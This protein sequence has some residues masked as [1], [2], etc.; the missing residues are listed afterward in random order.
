MYDDIQNPPQQLT[1]SKFKPWF[2]LLLFPLYLFGCLWALAGSVAGWQELLQLSNL[3]VLSLV[4]IVFALCMLIW[5]SYKLIQGFNKL[6]ECSRYEVYLAE[7]FENRDRQRPAQNAMR[8]DYLRKLR[9]QNSEV[10]GITESGQ[11]QLLV[12]AMVGL[13]LMLVGCVGQLVSQLAIS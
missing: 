7:V 6:T 3:S 10:R 13:L 8:L 4:V 9:K 2:W 5:L 1:Q 12:L 11:K